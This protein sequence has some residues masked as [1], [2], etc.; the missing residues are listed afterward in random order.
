MPTLAASTASPT[1]RSR[2]RHLAGHT[3]SFHD[4]SRLRETPT[5]QLRAAPRG[6]TQQASLDAAPPAGLLRPVVPTFLH[7]SSLSLSLCSLTL[8][9]FSSLYLSIFLFLSLTLPL[10]RS[11][12]SLSLFLFCFCFLVSLAEKWHKFPHKTASSA[13]LLFNAHPLSLFLSS[14]SH[15]FSISLRIKMAENGLCSPRSVSLTETASS[16]LACFLSRKQQQAQACFSFLSFPS[17]LCFMAFKG[18]RT[19]PRSTVFSAISQAK[20]PAT[21][22]FS[23]WPIG[24]SLLPLFCQKM[25]KHWPCTRG[26]G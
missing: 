22:V 23:L 24:P 2:L 17:S 8:P 25:A 11:Y 5:Q 15:C 26:V 19:V 13:C 3:F 6:R 10:A 14:I 21:I 12:L 4:P 9:L 20:L 7:S 18:N 1:G 16:K